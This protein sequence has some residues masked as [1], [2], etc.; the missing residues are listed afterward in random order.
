MLQTFLNSRKKLLYL[1]LPLA[2]LCNKVTAQQFEP[3]N[4]YL[5]ST[6]F[7]E[8]I[9]GNL[10]II[11]SVPHGGYLEPDSIPDCPNCSTIRD[12]YTQEI[13]RGISTAFFEQT[14]CYPHVVINLLHRRKLDMN[15]DLE[16]ATGNFPLLENAWENYH[17]FVD[18]SKAQI[19]ENYAEGLF[20]DLHGHDIQRIELGYLLSKSELQMTDAQMDASALFEECSIRTLTNTNLQSLSFA[21]LL[22]GESSLG[23]LM[24]EKGFPAVPSQADPFPLDNEPYFIGGYNTSRHGSKNSGAVDAIQL[25]FNQ[26]I[27]FD[28]DIRE[29]LID[30]LASVLVDY[31]DNHYISAFSTN[32]CNEPSAIALPATFAKFKVSPNPSNGRIDILGATDNFEIRL[33]DIL[34]QEVYRNNWTGES[35]DLS[36]LTNGNYFLAIRDEATL[37]TTKIVIA[38]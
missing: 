23:T 30:S 33:F 15:R 16:E 2:L 21:E 17:D 31:M 7:I 36:F 8:Y 37:W 29:I 22:R 18:I 24:T 20:I 1:F 14:G 9:A 13:G 3:G 19:D 12:A 32:L 4:S 10:P 34:G 26:S 35:F 25:E 28:I 6:D 5:D 27:R 38:K 11:V